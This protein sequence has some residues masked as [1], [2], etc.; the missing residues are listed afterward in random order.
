MSKKTIMAVIGFLPFNF[1]L[2]LP[3]QTKNTAPVMR[4]QADAAMQQLVLRLVLSFPLKNGDIV[5]VKASM[6]RAPPDA[7]IFI[8]T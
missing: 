8:K 2:S 3:S 7:L 4:Y 5:Q 6:T 1:C